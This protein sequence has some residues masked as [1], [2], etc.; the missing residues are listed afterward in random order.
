LLIYQKVHEHMCSCTARPP[1]SEHLEIPKYLRCEYYVALC[2]RSFKKL[3]TGL[4]EAV[5][6]SQLL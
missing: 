5:I 4:E 6:L 3:V 1:S 2:A